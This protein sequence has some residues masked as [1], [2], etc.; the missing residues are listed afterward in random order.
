MKPN[1]VKNDVRPLACIGL[2]LIVFPQYFLLDKI[3]LSC[4]NYIYVALFFKRNILILAAA[5]TPLLET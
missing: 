2:A 5:T 3:T 4:P 1:K